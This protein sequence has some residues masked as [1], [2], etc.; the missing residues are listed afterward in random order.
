MSGA[1]TVTV[2]EVPSS[3]AALPMMTMNA[4]HGDFFLAA[5]RRDDVTPVET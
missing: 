2:D 4:L 1:I 3:S 5:R